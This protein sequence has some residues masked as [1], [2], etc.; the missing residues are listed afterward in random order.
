MSVFVFCVFVTTLVLLVA[1][2]LVP[3]CLL[4][5]ACWLFVVAWIAGCWLL[6]LVLGAWCLVV[7]GWWVSG[8]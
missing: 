3:C 5:V 8:S 1:G 2:T 4:L 7:G 6:V